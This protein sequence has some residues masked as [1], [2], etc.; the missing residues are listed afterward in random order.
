MHQARFERARR[1]L[2]V[3]T[4]APLACLLNTGL[5]SLRA[6]V[7]LR[8]GVSPP[9]DPTRVLHLPQV[10]WPGVLSGFR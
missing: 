2:P 6:P 4:R 10:A 8:S 9:D 7:Y 5:V 3:L 1:D